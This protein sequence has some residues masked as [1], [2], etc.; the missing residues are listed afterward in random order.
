MMLQGT[1]RLKVC[2][3]ILKILIVGLYRKSFYVGRKYESQRLSF[4]VLNSRL[5]CKTY[6]RS[7]SR[8]PFSLSEII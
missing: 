4:Q 2:G 5:E 6:K 3:P 7:N 1:Q 8:F